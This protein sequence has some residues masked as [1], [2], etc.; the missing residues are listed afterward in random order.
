AGRRTPPPRTTPGWAART[1]GTGGSSGRLSA[2][3][4]VPLGVRPLLHRGWIAFELFN[5]FG[6]VFRI[7]PRR[8]GYEVADPGRGR[9]LACRRRGAPLSFGGRFAGNVSL[10][11]Q[12]WLARIRPRSMRRRTAKAA[13]ARGER[14]VGRDGGVGRPWAKNS[15]TTCS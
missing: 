15:N 2:S 11:F 10:H 6:G 7:V 1:L 14:P 4:H 9:A 8:G 13:A 3:A 5:F 12:T